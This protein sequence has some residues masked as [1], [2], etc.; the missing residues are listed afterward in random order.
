MLIV[1]LYL[2]AIIA[3]NFSA[4]YF[5]PWSTPI[6]SFLLIGF[7]LTARDKLHERWHG[8]R[9]LAKMTTLICVGSALTYLINPSAGRIALASAVSFGL[10][11]F[12]DFSIYQLLF[13]RHRA[14]KING[15]NIVSSAVDS[16]SFPTIAF[17][18][19]LPW[20][21]LLQF[22]AK[23]VGGFAW[24]WVIMRRLNNGGTGAVS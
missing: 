22:A 14:I 16:I 7:D 21:V 24:S 18:A 8:S 13:K 5:G 11:A 19:F 10:A 15:S 12:A 2:A 1:V 17:G 20:I 4:W 6:N 9:L 3:A 23:V